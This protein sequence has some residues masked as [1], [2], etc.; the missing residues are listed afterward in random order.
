MP[1]AKDTLLRNLNSPCLILRKQ[2]PSALSTFSAKWRKKR[3][4]FS[5]HSLQGVLVGL[6]G[7][8]ARFYDTQYRL[9]R[10]SNARNASSDLRTPYSAAALSFSLGK[11]YLQSLSPPEGNPLIPREIF[12]ARLINPLMRGRGSRE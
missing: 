7:L 2:Q 5:L 1:K 12:T 11:E 8:S 4:M 9:W 3:V 10:R 6:S